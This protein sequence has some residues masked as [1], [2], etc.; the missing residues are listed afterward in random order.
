MTNSSSISNFFSSSEGATEK[1]GRKK[2][3][4]RKGKENLEVDRQMLRGTSGVF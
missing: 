2:H 4:E 3:T 1:R